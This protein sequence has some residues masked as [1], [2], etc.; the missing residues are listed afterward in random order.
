MRKGV[1]EREREFKG[2]CVCIFPV[3]LFARAASS[4][5]VRSLRLSL[6]LEEVFP[7]LHLKLE[8]RLDEVR[9][10]GLEG[11]LERVAELLGGVGARGGDA[12]PRGQ[13]DPVDLLTKIRKQM[14]I[15]IQNSK[16]E[17]RKYSKNH[18]QRGGPE[19]TL[20]F[21]KRRVL[22]GNDA[23]PAWIGW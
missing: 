2:V 10:L 16:L 15:G 5:C 12:V 1:H 9:A 22:L 8:A 4:S 6:S 21:S 13:R 23:P 3:I 18:S 11:V 14:T 17:I 20:S 7:R 19:N